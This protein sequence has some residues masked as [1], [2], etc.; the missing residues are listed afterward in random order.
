MP[1]KSRIDT[2]GALPYI[3]G[4]RIERKR[5]FQNESDRNDFLK[6]MFRD[7]QETET[8]CLAWVLMANHVL[9]SYG[10]SSISDTDG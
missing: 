7:Q 4:R 1:R 3:I 6:R 10:I 5:I 2:V 8:R 9:E